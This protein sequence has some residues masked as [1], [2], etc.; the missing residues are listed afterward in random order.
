MYLS[1]FSPNAGKCREND[2]QNNSEYGH[3]LFSVVDSTL[4]VTKR[5]GKKIQRDFMKKIHS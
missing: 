4:T 5:S 1:V 2:N 3:F